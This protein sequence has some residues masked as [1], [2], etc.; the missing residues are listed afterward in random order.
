[1]I[2]DGAHNPAGARALVS[3]WR[4]EYG[5]AKATLILG[6]M[7]DKDVASV[8][9]VLAPIAA[10]IFAVAVENPRALPAAEL[11]VAVDRTAPGVVVQDFAS[12]SAA[13]QHAHL[14]EE[15]ILVAGSLFLVGAALVELGLAKAEGEQSSQ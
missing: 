9:A 10:R 15:R 8:I 13:L 11:A 5:D 4:S 7:R 12:L 14:H 3:T 1:V 6:M 2:L